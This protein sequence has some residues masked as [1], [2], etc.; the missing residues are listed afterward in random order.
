M[1][2]RH[3]RGISAAITLCAFLV[4]YLFVY[5]LRPLHLMR[6]ASIYHLHSYEYFPLVRLW[7]ALF[8]GRLVYDAHDFYLGIQNDEEL[9][10]VQ[11][12]WIRPFLLWLEMRCVARADVFLTVNSGTADLIEKQFGR[13]PLVLRNCHD[14]RLDHP[15]ARS[16]REAVGL[17]TEDLLV[18]ATGNWKQGHATREAIEALRLLP[19]NVHLAFVGAGYEQY[20]AL[21]ERKGLARRVHLAGS[22]AANEVVPF[23][24]S[25]DAALLLY[26]QH[27]ANYANALPNGFFQSLAAGLPLIYSDLPGMTEMAAPYDLAPAVDSQSPESIANALRQVLLDPVE[28]RSR[29]EAARC[30]S[31]SISFEKEAIILREILD[32][33]AAC[34]TRVSQCAE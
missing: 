7:C 23:I 24:A 32:A 28:R 2:R 20:R 21:A 11:R 6:R 30:F 31:A 16:L 25:A 19:E 12:R 4:Y 15:P 29:R 3:G 34:R 18:V 33:P 5:C 9:L 26:H 10:P 27:N 17:G 1:L 14:S 8:G 13:R 22:V